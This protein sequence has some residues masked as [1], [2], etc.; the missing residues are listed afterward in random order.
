[1]KTT[2]LARAPLTLTTLTLALTTAP[3]TATAAPRT[4]RDHTVALSVSPIHLIFPML[5]AQAEFYLNDYVSLSLIGGI[6]QVTVEVNG[7]NGAFTVYE[8]GGQ[9]RGYFYGGT[10]EGAYGAGEFLHIQIDGEVDGVTGLGAGTAIGP[11]IGY[12]WTWDNFFLD[13]NGGV[14]IT[15]IS[16]EAE[17]ARTGEQA[18]DEQ[19]QFI[20][21]LNFN[22]GW[23]F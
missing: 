6:G 22:L 16:A 14:L 9:I 4:D 10:E 8:I 23:S 7:E 19:S 2:P 1:M 17:D 20:P 11:L 5:E 18:S 12:K 3:L 15:I 13:L 21:T